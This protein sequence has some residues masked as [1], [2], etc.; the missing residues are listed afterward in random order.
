MYFPVAG[1]LAQHLFEVKHAIIV[2]THLQHTGRGNA[3]L[4]AGCAEKP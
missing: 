2:K 1:T 3:D 4:V